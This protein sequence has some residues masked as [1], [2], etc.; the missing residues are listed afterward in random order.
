MADYSD[1]NNNNALFN[2]IVDSDPFL[3]GFFASSRPIVDAMTKEERDRFVNKIIE[4]G[5]GK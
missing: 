4:I 5:K 2:T 1:S 3:K